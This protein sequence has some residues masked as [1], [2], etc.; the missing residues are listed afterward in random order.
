MSQ[1]I[2]TLLWNGASVQALPP[3]QS[4]DFPAVWCE[5]NQP[6]LL[7]VTRVK[8]KV[9]KGPICKISRLVK[10]WHFGM[11]ANPTY[12]HKAA[13]FHELGVRLRNQLLQ[14]SVN[15]GELFHFSPVTSS[16]PKFFILNLS[17]LR[18]YMCIFVTITT[19]ITRLW[20]SSPQS[21]MEW[22]GVWL[23]L[24]HKQCT[25]PESLKSR[26]FYADWWK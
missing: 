23:A 6:L 19:K 1:I 12:N 20:I 18:S 2:I 11:A 3:F 14:S 25:Q 9:S 7:P 5:Y 10:Y 8:P 13:V 24:W 4:C 16:S 22:T 17:K 26:Y 21:F 15:W